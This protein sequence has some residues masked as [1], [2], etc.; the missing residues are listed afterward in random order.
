MPPIP[1]HV[2]RHRLFAFSLLV[3]SILAVPGTLLAMFLAG[4][5]PS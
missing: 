3:L 2:R 1:D 5:L 4:F